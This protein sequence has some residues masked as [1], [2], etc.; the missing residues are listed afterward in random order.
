[1]KNRKI[2]TKNEALSILGKAAKLYHENLEGRDLLILSKNGKDVR[3]Y[4]V[5]FLNTNFQHFTGTISS[6]L[7]ASDFYDAALNGQLSIIDFKFKNDDLTSMKLDILEQAV[8]FQNTAKMIGIFNG[9]RKELHADIGAGN[10]QYVMTF[11]FN[12]SKDNEWLYPVGVQEE[13]VRDVTTRSPIIAI[14][15][16]NNN[17]K[18][19]D[20]ITYKSKKISIEKLH[21]PKAI[22]DKLSDEAYHILKPQQ[23]EQLISQKQVHQE[24]ESQ[25]SFRTDRPSSIAERIAQKQ[26]Y[27]QQRAP[28]KHTHPHRNS[29]Q[30]L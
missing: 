24:K 9:P 3:I 2:Y 16:K 27:I 15:R 22:R 5:A 23:T 29:D 14:F 1:M 13:D 30:E 4:E 18:I 6:N 21:F 28:V 19:Y 26:K 20:E 10:V 11:R 17:D 25:V 7:S 12:E 8:N